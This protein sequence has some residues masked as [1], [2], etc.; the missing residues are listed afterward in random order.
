MTG[1]LLLCVALSA[2]FASFASAQS[3]QDFSTVR[4][5]PAPG[6]GNFVTVDG[7]KVGSH[8]NTSYGVFLESAANT[9]VV[10]DECATIPNVSPL[11]KNREVAFVRQTSLAHVTAALSLFG[12]AQI[13]LELPLGFTDADRYDEVTTAGNGLHIKPHEGFSLADSR[14]AAKVRVFGE[15]DDSLTMAAVVSSTVPTASLTS[16][17]DCTKFEQCSFLGERGAQVAGMFVSEFSV[18]EFRV[19]VNV[20]AAYR[21]KRSFLDTEVGSEVRYGLAGAYNATPL[22]RLGAEVTGS[23]NLLGS[24][25]YPL[26][27]RGF[28]GYGQD[29]QITAGGGAGIL[30]DVGSPTYR[31]FLGMQYQPLTHDEDGDGIDDDDDACPADDEDRDGFAD[32]DGCPETD[33]DG[34]AVLD[35]QDKCPN[36]AEDLD[37]FQDEDGCPELDNDGDGVPDGYDSCEG[38]KE[39]LDGDRD[40]DGCPD[41]DTDRD[42]VDDAHDKCPNEGEDTDGLG[43]DDGCPET[44]FDGDGVKDVEDACPDAT[45][46]WNDILDQD[47]C[48]EDDADNDTVPD[49]TDRCP[50]AAETL[51]GTA[52]ADGCPDGARTMILKGNTLLPTDTPVFDKDVLRGSPVLVDT[53][54]DYVKRNHR[55]GSVRVVVVA[56]AAQAAEATARAQHLAGLLGRRLNTTVPGVH[57]EGT[58]L[59]VE[60]ELLPPGWTELPRS[61]SA[62]TTPASITAAPAAPMSTTPAPAAAPKEPAPA[63]PAPAAPAPH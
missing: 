60:I 41:M 1:R 21:P 52:D 19:A 11:C 53:I 9:L 2:S 44:D 26:E 58:P 45:E 4:F 15:P 29:F 48:P 33:N 12:R 30:G 54:A 40:D 56:P 51:N 39:D 5:S 34:D 59:H 55:R 38:Q 3:K 23:A 43:D 24:D 42:G 62:S 25:D 17:G 32:D 35:A 49:A 16:H 10:H 7:A 31:V 14:I 61:R 18:P 50:D 20:G 27:A 6:A 8:L 57:I 13:G 37:K 28:L 47:G 46:W 63:A 36:D 22:F